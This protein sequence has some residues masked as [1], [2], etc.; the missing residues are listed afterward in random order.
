ME[1]QET[2]HSVCGPLA[3]SVGDLRLFI[4]AVLEQQPWAFDSKVVP[5]PW[6]QAEEDAVTKKL[7]SGGLTLGFYSCDGNVRVDF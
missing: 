7:S 2:I 4:K 6:R 1:G 3:H 5:M